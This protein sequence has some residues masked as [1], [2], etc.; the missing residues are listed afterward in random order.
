MML[1][2]CFTFT[3]LKYKTEIK[4]YL[5]NVCGTGEKPEVEHHETKLLWYAFIVIEQMF[6]SNNFVINSCSNLYEQFHQNGLVVKFVYSKEQ[7]EHQ[8]AFFL[9]NVVFVFL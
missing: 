9:Q 8:I 7:N 6:S 4:I 3:F 2:L 1:I 5:K